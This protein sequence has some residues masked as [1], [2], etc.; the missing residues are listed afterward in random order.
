MS[1]SH[2]GM[3]SCAPMK[4]TLTS[5]DSQEKNHRT[6]VHSAMFK[7]NCSSYV[8]MNEYFMSISISKVHS[9]NNLLDAPWTVTLISQE[10]TH[11]A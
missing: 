4:I 5:R 7:S 9:R 8:Y 3:R 1:A 11:N 2:D 6:S 10:H